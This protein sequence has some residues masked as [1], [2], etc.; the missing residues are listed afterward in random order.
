MMNQEQGNRETDFGAA[1]ACAE[2]YLRLAEPAVISAMELEESTR[3][4]QFTAGLGDVVA[5]ATNLAFAIELY[6]KAILVVSKI[7]MP[8][9]RE[10]HNLGRL[11]A[12]MPQH[13]RT[14]IESAYAE[15]RKSDWSGR[16]PSMTLS[17]RPVTTG[18]PK[19]D[20]NRNESID[21]HALLNRSSDIFT[22]W[23]YIYE[24]KRP[25]EGTWHFRRLEYALLLSA[26]RAMRDTVSWLQR[27][28]R[29]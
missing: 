26:C 4:Q 18:V 27:Q 13:F 2:A 20:D 21:L 24:F 15:T 3:A 6:M 16:Y 23:R 19:W 25:D 11:Y 17:V 5:G 22:S 7:D 12:L 9:G 28:D 10:G 29:K 14:V 8:R 1:L